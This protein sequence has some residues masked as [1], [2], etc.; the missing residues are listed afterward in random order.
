MENKKR[1]QRKTYT[2]FINISSCSSSL[3]YRNRSQNKG[4]KKKT[5]SDWPRFRSLIKEKCQGYVE[6]DTAIL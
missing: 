4:I 6:T 3:S 2:W 5:L 1:S